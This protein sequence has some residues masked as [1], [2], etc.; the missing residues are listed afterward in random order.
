MHTAPPRP[1]AIPTNLE[2]EDRLAGPFTARQCMILAV[3]AAVA[4]AEAEALHTGLRLASTVIA[5]CTAP[6]ILAGL[7]LALA[8]PGGIPA[9]RLAYA[10]IRFLRSG[11]RQA[12]CPPHLAP[13]AGISRL[14]PLYRGLAE[15]D[16]CGIAVLDGQQA[17]V[18]IEARPRCL[19]LA[20]AD[21]IRAALAAIGTLVSAQSG[22][23]TISTLTERVSLDAHAEQ[24][25]ETASRLAT[26]ELSALAARQAEYLR[27]VADERELWHRRH[28]IT[29]RESGPGAAARAGHR[30]QAAAQLLE[31]CGMSA[32]VLD[33]G[34]LTALLT[35]A[36]DPRRAAA[37]RRLAPSDRVVVAAPAF[38]LID[39]TSR[40]EQA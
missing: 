28:L 30:A 14:A 18:V 25:G 17:A 4:L 32:R 5:A 9:D 2:V 31:S 19:Q 16:G 26:P 35:A 7:L 37:P 39:A 8:K 38:D 36:C 12:A 3:T 10:A 24:A 11:R 20:D 34:E 21:E 27:N 1:V 6:L 29:I 23:F 13:P 22:P 15:Q 33:P 40:Q